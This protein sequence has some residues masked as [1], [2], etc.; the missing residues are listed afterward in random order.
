MTNL[1]TYLDLKYDN[2]S[3]IFE[4][5][6][7][8]Y[9]SIDEI[10]EGE[11]LYESIIEKLQAHKGDEIDEGLLGSLVGGAAGMLVG[12]AIGRAI[13]KALGIAESGVLGQLMT[14][15]LVTTAIGL[16]LGK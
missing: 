7:I 10:K 13:C 1:P 16:E 3:Q 11:K 5:E 12:P 15:R 6:E 14:S 9:L 4:S 2:K 8:K